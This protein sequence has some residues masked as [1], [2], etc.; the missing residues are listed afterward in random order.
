MDVDG[1]HESYGGHK[2]S[3]AAATDTQD[4]VNQL[5]STLE[6]VAA[7][8]NNVRL[9]RHQVDLMLDLGMVDEATDA[10]ETAT[11]IGFLGESKCSAHSLP[12]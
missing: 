10:I 7:S 1:G 6:S 8:P 11:D 12:C 3:A 5:G 2:S 4:L 9:L